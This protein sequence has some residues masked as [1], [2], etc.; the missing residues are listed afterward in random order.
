LIIEREGKIENLKN[1][2]DNKKIQIESN[3]LAKKE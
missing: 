3:F 2:I 1:K